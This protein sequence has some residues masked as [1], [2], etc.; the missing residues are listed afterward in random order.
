MFLSD[1]AE[2][3]CSGYLFWSLGVRNARATFEEAVRATVWGSGG[4]GQ[5]LDG[6]VLIQFALM[7]QQLDRY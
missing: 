6:Q 5:D 2:Q 3:E 7:Q 4:A 1:G